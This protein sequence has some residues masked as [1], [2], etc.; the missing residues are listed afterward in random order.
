MTI[1]RFSQKDAEAL[2]AKNEKQQREEKQK[3]ADDKA[4]AVKKVSRVTVGPKVDVDLSSPTVK[5]FIESAPDG[6]KNVPNN[7]KKRTDDGKWQLR[8]NKV[9]ITLGLKPEDLVALDELTE[10]EGRTRTE[11]LTLLI[12]RAVLEGKQP[13]NGVWR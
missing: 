10:S 5:S 12:R 11:L 13:D 9:T 7:G 8:G 6:A 1:A 3:S 2:K 4:K